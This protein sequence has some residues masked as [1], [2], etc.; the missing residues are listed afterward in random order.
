MHKNLQSRIEMEEQMQ[1]T[2]D[3]FNAMMSREFRA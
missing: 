1:V 2:H 3:V